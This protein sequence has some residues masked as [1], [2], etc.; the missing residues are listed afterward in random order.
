MV[1]VILFYIKA[2]YGRFQR[3]GW[4]F[5]IKARWAWIL[6]ELPA[7]LFPLLLFISYRAWDSIP[8]IIMLI[9]WEFHYFHRTFI[10]P[11][12]FGSPNK[13][14]PGLIVLF[15][16]IFNCINGFI[17]GYYLFHLASFSNEWLLS[18]YFIAGIT[19]FLLGYWI[20]KQADSQLR[21]LK[22]IGGTEYKA[23]RKGLFNWISNP[24]YF[25]E[26]LEWSGWA[27]LTLSLPGLAFAVFTFAN[28]APR[29]WSHHQW[30]LNKF[31]EYPKNRK[32]LI[33]FL[34]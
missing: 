31:P 1:F 13:P 4:G 30:Y 8:A 23:P 33:P 9:I 24:H 27:L 34:W 29:A 19:L 2:P 15:A 32:A 14:Y 22:L 12:R 3:P 21:S 28:L 10:Y 5:T 7:F 26:I 16:I 18:P 25:G 17:N 6:Q 20:N 11:F